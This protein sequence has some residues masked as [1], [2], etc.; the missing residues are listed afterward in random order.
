MYAYILEVKPSGFADGFD[1]E[2]KKNQ[3]VKDA[4]RFGT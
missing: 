1:M 4:P 2:Y 3:E